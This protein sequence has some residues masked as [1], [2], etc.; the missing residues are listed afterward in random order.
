VKLVDGPAHLAQDFAQTLFP[1][2]ADRGAHNRDDGQR[3]DAHHRHRDD[4]FDERPPA[5]TRRAREEE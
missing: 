1:L 2:A 5:R 3:Q 4:Q